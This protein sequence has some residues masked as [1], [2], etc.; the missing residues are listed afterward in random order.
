MFDIS[1][2]KLLF[3]P[4]HQ[5]S[6]GYH[7]SRTTPLIKMSALISPLKKFT[8]GRGLKLLKHNQNWVFLRKSRIFRINLPLSASLDT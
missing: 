8:P 7:S 6:Y 4:E 5:I 2:F 1:A 3:L